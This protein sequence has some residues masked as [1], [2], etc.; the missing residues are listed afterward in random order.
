MSTAAH[1][2][3]EPTDVAPTP[4]RTRATI[5]LTCLGVF[6]SYLPM[7]GISVALPVLQKGLDASTT[8]LLWITDAFVL[9]TATLLLTCGMLG[10]LYGRKKTYLG[11]LALFCIGYL[12][13][14]T[15]SSVVQ[16]CVG[17]AL[18]GVGTAALLPTTLALIS[19]VCPD[20]RK[21]ATA[22]ALWTASLGLGLTLG[23]LF[24]GLIAEWMSWPWIFSPALIIAAVP[25][26]AGA[27]LLTESRADRERH[28]DIPGQLLAIIALT[29]LISGVIEGGSSGWKSPGAVVALVVAMITLPA[30]V[31]AELRSR[32][33]MLDMRLFRSAK[34]SG[35]ALAMVLTLFAQ[36]GL[37]FALSEYFGLV[38]HTS[39][40]DG[41]IRLIALSGFTVVLGPLVGQLMNRFTPGLLLAVGLAIGGVG[42]LCVLLFHVDTDVATE[43]LLLGVLGPRHRVSTRTDHHN[44]HGQPTAEPRGNGR[45]REQRTTPDR[46]CPRPG[47]LRSHPH[48][49]NTADP[50]RTHRTIRARRHRPKPHPR[51]GRRRRHT[52][53]RIPAPEH[54]RHHATGACRLRSRSHR[55]ATH[56]RP[57]RRHRDVG[58]GSRRAPTDRRTRQERP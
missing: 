43:L 54:S 36:V 41:G 17:Q 31:V 15:A 23:P 4:W 10:D 22:I 29:G 35:A 52:G 53:R 1:P 26:V 48:R 2:A 6:V 25:L 44:R 12:V 20:P 5:A 8:E 38:H 24:T 11:G 9:P 19:H 32:H 55:R 45:L 7:V 50:A 39:T 57:R 58:I 37:V 33:P 30:F 49:A 40:L 13:C 21:R 27:A 18:A 3:P 56:L 14:L 28:L 16:V 42:A 34:F 51:H 47:D 46:Q